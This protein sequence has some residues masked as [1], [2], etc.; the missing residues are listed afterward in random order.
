MQAIDGDSVHGLPRRSLLRA[1]SPK[2][3]SP[4]LRIPHRR[5][6]GGNDTPI[7][8]DP[9]QTALTQNS[10]RLTQDSLGS[11]RKARLLKRKAEREHHRRKGRAD[12]DGG[13]V[14]SA[15]LSKK[16]KL[17]ATIGIGVGAVMLA[18]SN[19]RNIKKGSEYVLGR[20]SSVVDTRTPNPKN[21]TEAR[22]TDQAMAVQ[23]LQDES[24]IPKSYQ[25][26]NATEFRTLTPGVERSQLRQRGYM[27]YETL[28]A[29][30]GDPKDNDGAFGKFTSY[31]MI[32][33]G[34]IMAHK[35]R[36]LS[37][38]VT[39][40]LQALVSDA[41]EGSIKEK[42]V[43]ILT[44]LKTNEA[45]IVA[46]NGLGEAA[47][48]PSVDKLAPIGESMNDLINMENMSKEKK[49]DDGPTGPILLQSGGRTG[50]EE[51]YQHNR[52]QLQR[53]MELRQRAM[54]LA[55]AVPRPS[56]ALAVQAHQTKE[57]L[58]SNR[59]GAT[60]MLQARLSLFRSFLLKNRND[61]LT[62]SELWDRLTLT[63]LRYWQRPAVDNDDV[64]NFVLYGP[65]GT[66]KTRMAENVA[67]FFRL[68]GIVINFRDEMETLDS[69]SFKAMHYGESERVTQHKLEERRED[70]LYV[71]EAHTLGASGDNTGVARQVF[72]KIMRYLGNNPRGIICILSGYKDEIQTQL[73]GM[74]PGAARRFV[75][76]DVVPYTPAMLATIFLRNLH[77]HGISGRHFIRS[78]LKETLLAVLNIKGLFRESAASVLKLRTHIETA[79]LDSDF[80]QAGK[81][82]M[83]ILNDEQ[84]EKGRSAIT[85]R[86]FF[87]GV[88][89]YAA[90]LGIELSTAHPFG[91]VLKGNPE[92][93]DELSALRAL[94]DD[95]ENQ[96][97]QAEQQRIS[98]ELTSL[99][100]EMTRHNGQA[101]TDASRD[102]MTEFMLRQSKRAQDQGIIASQR[103]K[104]AY[105]NRLLL[106]SAET[107][108][109]L[110]HVRNMALDIIPAW[111]DVQPFTQEYKS[112]EVAC[113]D[114]A[115][116][117]DF[118][119]LLAKG[120][121]KVSVY[122]HQAGGGGGVQRYTGVLDVRVEKQPMK[123]A[124]LVTFYVQL[125]AAA[126]PEPNEKKSAQQEN[127]YA[128]L[129]VEGEGK[130]FLCGSVA[131]SE[132]GK[133]SKLTGVVQ[134]RPVATA[135]WVFSHWEP[136]G[137]TA[138][139]PVGNYVF[140]IQTDNNI[141]AIFTQLSSL[142]PS[143]RES[144]I[145]ADA[146]R[147]V[148][149][150][151]ET[152]ETIHLLVRTEVQPSDQ[153]VEKQCVTF[154]V[155]QEIDFAGNLKSTQ[156]PV[157]SLKAPP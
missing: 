66:G 9:F 129:D 103:N 128:L 119:R 62:R 98:H 125:T 35:V 21:S 64:T 142:V 38:D 40:V 102:A 104:Q 20:L 80:R 76:M 136:K 97:M 145:C 152:E 126:E 114:S 107:E 123:G 112:Q 124:M 54:Y 143:E 137:V 146:W 70:A 34:K 27:T 109:Q 100:A 51:A 36:H 86:L 138:R 32:S 147:E 48:P 75:T 25:T 14:S 85:Q 12:L 111:S 87:D 28:L 29:M 120:N 155:S 108:R 65:P 45:N 153:D 3:H 81:N 82:P 139:S 151:A 91:I 141:K 44:E 60:K 49:E 16:N 5:V 71:D 13:H 148:A 88:R 110:Q 79:A 135:G 133:K 30:V 52:V 33:V 31:Y 56:K 43:A 37:T 61:A 96:R 115:D 94:E 92:R 4:P 23:L 149:R 77:V 72:S 93:D 156:D 74:D 47:A 1:R 105:Q 42:L 134:L 89:R 53:L 6:A 73:F 140:Q 116:A 18:L 84:K 58:R 8:T 150:E 90:T 106:E 83:A 59:E 11:E 95:E 67:L 117:E 2:K 17:Y 113:G 41:V 55:A 69:S 10:L 131:N 24:Q 50:R 19:Y 118:R 57:K 39:L 68:G 101:S 132:I 78:S 127:E 26:T 130:V 46:L 22:T 7:L 63:L 154:I 122:T 15:L 121:Q 157:L 144:R 99:R